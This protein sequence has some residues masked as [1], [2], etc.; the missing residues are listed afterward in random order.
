LLASIE[1]GTSLDELRAQVLALPKEQAAAG[2]RGLAAAGEEQAVPLLAD[3]AGAADRALAE[4]AVE[5]LG[6]VRAQAAAEALDEIAASVDDKAVQKAARRSIFRLGSQGIR[7]EP[8]APTT[9]SIAT[10]RP[11]TLYRVI[12]SAY[13]GSGSRSMWFGAERRLGGIYLVA[14]VLNDVDGLVD[15]AGRDT[16]RKRFSEQEA[17]MREKDITAW[18]ELPNDY[19]CQL[20][21]EG[22]DLAQASGQLL[23]PGYA[24]WADLIGNPPEP[25]SQALVYAEISAFETRMHPTLEG[26]TPRLFTQPEVESWFFRPEEV[27]KWLHQLAET[28]G[29]RLLV[30]PESE[31]D[32]VERVMREAVKEL[33]PPARRAGLKRRLEE[34]AYIFLRTDRMADARRAVQAAATIEEERPLRPPHPFLRALMERSLRIALEVERSDFE[35]TRLARVP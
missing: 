11:A 21:Q 28:P 27:Q 25:F 9:A 16:T 17:T 15:C 12:A 14:V 31:Q 24:M 34:T 2:L 3:V 1:Q 20:V 13:D 33:L 30:T 19:A 35:P 22:V 10:T 6:D 23:P 18:V 4:A 26:E 29:S 32:R 7:V 8:S 5:A